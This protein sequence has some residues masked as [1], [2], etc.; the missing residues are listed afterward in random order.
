MKKIL[1]IDD[2]PTILS[3]MKKMVEKAGY[4]ADMASNGV[5]AMELIENNSYDLVI[6]DIIMP[7]KEGLE[8][9]S[10]IRKH[11]SSIK[12]IAISGGGRLSPEEYLQSAKYL[13]ALKVLKKPFA[14]QDFL[15]AIKEL[16]G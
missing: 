9:I 13:G 7:E 5:E 3:M 8:I 4:N 14:Q 1:L 15:S 12:V 11:H 2:E 16:I 10:E 6:T